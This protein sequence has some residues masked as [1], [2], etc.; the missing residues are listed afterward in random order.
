M[1]AIGWTI[2]QILCKPAYL[3][4]NQINVRFGLAN[5]I[6]K[7]LSLLMSLGNHSPHVMSDGCKKGK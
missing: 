2:V 5:T 1:L 3:I 6:S 7:P 4:N